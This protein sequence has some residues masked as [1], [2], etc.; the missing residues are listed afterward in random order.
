MRDHIHLNAGEVAARLQISTPTLYRWVKKKKF[1]AGEHAD[2]SGMPG[3][4]TTTLWDICTVDQW[5]IDNNVLI[6]IDPTLPDR[7]YLGL[8][9]DPTRVKHGKTALYAIGAAAAAIAYLL[10]YSWGI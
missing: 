2:R 5:A 4:Q 7:E 6:R 9:D 8:A 10:Y 3:P 1:P